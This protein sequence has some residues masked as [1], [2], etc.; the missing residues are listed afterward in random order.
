MSDANRKD[1]SGAS[2]A[3]PKDAKDDPTKSKS[4]ETSPNSYGGFSLER[5]TASDEGTD[6]AERERGDEPKP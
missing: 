2:E 5:P 4:A 3:R 6:V 1:G